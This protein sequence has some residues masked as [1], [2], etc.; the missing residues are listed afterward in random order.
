MLR[1]FPSLGGVWRVVIVL[2]FFFF[3]DTATTEISPLSLH[4]ALPIFGPPR[5][6]SRGSVRRHKRRQ[7]QGLSLPRSEEHTSELQSRLHLVCR[8]S[9]GKKNKHPKRDRSVSLW[10]YYIRLGSCRA[11]RAAGSPS[12]DRGDA[13]AET[14]GLYWPFVDLVLVFINAL[15]Y[16]SSPSPCLPP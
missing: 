9:L 8:L 16:L 6:R 11:V 10:S 4:D 5:F 14:R 7:S 15:S 12:V 2:F 1:S 3:N 13:V